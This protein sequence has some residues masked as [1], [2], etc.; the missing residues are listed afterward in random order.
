MKIRIEISIGDTIIADEREI[1]DE[2]FKLARY[3]SMMM[4]GVKQEL[5]NRMAEAREKAITEFQVKSGMDDI[6]ADLL[7]GEWS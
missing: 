2:M 4:G 6:T 1:P 7:K 3:P 5:W